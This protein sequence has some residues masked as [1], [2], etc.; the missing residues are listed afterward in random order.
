MLLRFSSRPIH[1]PG[2]GHPRF[3]RR[4]VRS[5]K[6]LFSRAHLVD[7]LV[8]KI[9][10]FSFN[11]PLWRMALPFKSYKQFLL[12]ISNVVFLLMFQI[13]VSFCSE[14]IF[15]AETGFSYNLPPHIF[16][17]RPQFSFTKIYLIHSGRSLK[18]QMTPVFFASPPLTTQVEFE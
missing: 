15:L 14:D 1:F 9:K 3:P 8:L 4:T 12:R 2:T 13:S 11:D 18:L 10:L 16:Q 5:F 7:P 6:T 17:Q